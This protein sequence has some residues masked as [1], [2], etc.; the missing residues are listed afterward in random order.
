MP[1]DLAGVKQPGAADLLEQLRVVVA[2]TDKV[3]L[4]GL[5]DSPRRFRVVDDGDLPARHFDFGVDAVQGDTAVLRR[6]RLQQP[7][8]GVVVAK[9]HVDRPPKCS[10]SMRSTNGAERSPQWIS[11][12]AP[13]SLASARAQ[14]SAGMWSWLSERMAILVIVGAPWFGHG[15]DAVLY[16][17]LYGLAA[18]ANMRTDTGESGGSRPPGSG[19]GRVG[20][21]AGW[22]DAGR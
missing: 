6:N 18:N 5:R 7:A 19:G 9:D 16:S 20:G 1:H 12:S 15:F 13:A 10:A 11:T 3:E 22:Q 17:S 21:H 4:A 8:I 14:A 2:V